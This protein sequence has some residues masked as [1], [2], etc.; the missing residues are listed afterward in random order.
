MKT[1]IAIAS[2]IVSTSAWAMP[3]VGDHAVYAATYTSTAVTQN[4]TIDRKISGMNLLAKTFTLD[5]TFT[6]GSQSQAQSEVVAAADMTTDAQVTDALTNCV[7]YGGKTES[8]TVAA[9]TFNTCALPTQD[10]G[11]IWVASGVPFAM[12]KTEGPTEDGGTIKA[13]LQSFE[14]GK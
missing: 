12:V 3:A 1:I 9:G 5:T 13:E 14:N 7:T 10:G 2:L 11:T 8:V 6:M 4:Y